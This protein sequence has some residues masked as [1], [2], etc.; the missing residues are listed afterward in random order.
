MHMYNGRL[1]FVVLNIGGTSVLV[2]NAFEAYKRQA[3]ESLFYLKHVITLISCTQCD[4]YIVC[5]CYRQ[6]KEYNTE[7]L[8]HSDM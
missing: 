8:Y 1:A 5:H 3:I 7:R 4:R 6:G 2:Y